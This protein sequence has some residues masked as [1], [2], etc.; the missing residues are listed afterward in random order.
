[1]SITRIC[2][3]VAR[4]PV[5]FLFYSFLASAAIGLLSF[6]LL[7]CRQ[8]G[9]F[10]SWLANRLQVSAWTECLGLQVN[11][12]DVQCLRAGCPLGI[13]VKD[14]SFRQQDPEKIAVDVQRVHLSLSEGLS[15]HK[16]SVN[17]G[18]E[19]DPITIERVEASFSARKITIHN[20]KVL[21]GANPGDFSLK[22]KE[23]SV[24]ELSFP[25]DSGETLAVRKLEVVEV[26]LFLQP[27]E[28]GKWSLAG[29]QPL[30][31]IRKRLAEKAEP[32]MET[33]RRGIARVR[34]GVRWALIIGTALF[35]FVKLLL[36]RPLPAPA[37]LR[38]LATLSVLF[39][40]GYYLFFRHLSVLW[41]LLASFLASLTVA[42]LLHRI[43]YR[44]GREFHQRW[45][46]FLLDLVSPVVFLP[47]LIVHG[48]TLSLPA[49]LPSTVSI[50]EFEAHKTRGVLLL[51]SNTP[52][53]T[54]V[55][56]D[57]PA[58]TANNISV[59]LGPALTELR[60]LDVDK[61]FLRGELET[62]FLSQPLEKV[63][64][65]PLEWKRDHRLALCLSATVTS[66]ES[67]LGS[68][69]ECPLVSGALPELAIGASVFI[70][71]SE[72]E[73]QFLTKT[74]LRTPLLDV[75]L[76]A[77]GNS[78]SMHI[79]RIES[80]GPK[81]SPVQIAGGSGTL[82]WERGLRTMIHLRQL[83]LPFATPRISADWAE[84]SASSSRKPEK[85]IL[86]T[87]LGGVTLATE[88][89]EEG[90]VTN[91]DKARI[92]SGE[93]WP[94]TATSTVGNSAASSVGRFPVISVP[95]RRV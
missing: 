63:Q 60:T 43:L 39:P 52:Q 87:D 92:R 72:R 62:N 88:A 37:S 8:G 3:W 74:R 4:H 34:T 36:L 29:A 66:H 91:I 14:I 93:A 41:L 16:I 21:L 50:A 30:S 25:P 42:V 80:L 5:R 31:S 1:M 22:L 49:G 90:Y 79:Q 61:V 45:E 46:P 17:T 24:S 73:L 23:L 44:R 68:P 86:T 55:R 11:S 26:D 54:F 6:A 38:V 84:I 15:I 57:I 47:L 40:F 18:L 82:S 83:A 53:A 95:W 28:D 78:R 67:S 32:L 75:W 12:L 10:E 81:E 85:L 51:D 9:A 7:L 56:L 59:G 33:F 35:L 20:T 13:V 65:I 77:D 69:P 27:G 2:D 71:P 58:I 48:F 70:A 94:I 64:Y 89:T 19:T 76:E